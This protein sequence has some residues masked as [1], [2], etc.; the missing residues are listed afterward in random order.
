[1]LIKKPPE[2][3][4]K[5]FVDKCAKATDLFTLIITE[6]KKKLILLMFRSKHNKED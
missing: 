4:L 3:F 1:M 5:V 6:R 2:K